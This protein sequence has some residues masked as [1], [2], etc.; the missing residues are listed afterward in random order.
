[1]REALLASLLEREGMV[2]TGL[3]KGIALPHPRHPQDWGLEGPT[4]G[5]FFL[6]A[7][8]DFH[9]LDGQAV[10]VMF[11]I[12]CGSIKS[13]LTMLAQLSLF[14][15]DANVGAFLETRPSRDAML[16]QIRHVIPA[17]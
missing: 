2:T 4:V 16:E 5:V 15:N 9:A 11:M 14:G 6:T 17:P 7:P 1:P 3:G 8:V 13:H 10:T 12:L